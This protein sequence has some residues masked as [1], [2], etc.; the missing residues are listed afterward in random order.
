MLEGHLRLAAEQRM[1]DAIAA[2]QQATSSE[3]V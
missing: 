3:E 1:E 2:E